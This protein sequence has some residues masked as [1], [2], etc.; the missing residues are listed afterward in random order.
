VAGEGVSLTNMKVLGLLV[1]QIV[2]KG[3]RKKGGEGV[4]LTNM[5]VLSLLVRQIVF[6]GKEE[7]HVNENGNTIQHLF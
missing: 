4:S 6:K 1:R 3:R 5:K 7:K 2:F